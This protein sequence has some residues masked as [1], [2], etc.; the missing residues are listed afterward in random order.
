MENRPAN[1]IAG[2]LSSSRF[3][4]TV[5]FTTVLIAV[6]LGALSKG[7]RNFDGDEI[8]Y[9]RVIKLFDSEL[10]V[11]L[12]RTYNSEPASPAP[13][14]F[15]VY[16]G[17]G[18]LFGFSYPA[19]RTLS[20]LLTLLA[21]LCVW[22]FLR[23]RRGDEPRDFFP[24]LLFL[25]PY[26]FCMG[27]SVMA[28]PLTLLFTIVGLCCYIYGL[29]QKSN[30]ALFLGSVAIVAALYVR[31]HAVFACAALI[32]ILLLQKDRSLLKWLLAILPILG[33][34]P[35][36]LLQGGLTVSRAA[37]TA[38]KPEFGLCLSHINF[39]FVWFGYMFFPLLWW[40]RTR[41]QINLLAVLVLIPFYFLLCPDFL[42]TEHGGALRTIFLKLG[43]EPGWVKWVLLPAW[44]IGC[45]MTIELI[46]RILSDKDITEV[47][48]CT[49]IVMFMAQL[50]FSTAAFERY[51]Q[52]AVPAIVLLGVKRTTRTSGYIAF[53]ICHLFFLAL[54][55]SRLLKDIV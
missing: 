2:V 10:S 35:L 17:W 52:L 47:F 6:G 7:R 31:I 26:I 54:A 40:A 34:L 1:L 45:Y 38:T 15:L 42:G 43:T 53:V 9:M 25:F 12:L 24:V 55:F 21:M 44:I 37:F 18:R 5:I 27:F 11:E 32:I 22:L 41:R 8:I 20:L 23:K 13:L 3:F 19:F 33:R 51:Y 4:W 50:I 29:K 28:E 30:F 16:A 36:V 46:Q 39:F 49:C 48:L 14:F